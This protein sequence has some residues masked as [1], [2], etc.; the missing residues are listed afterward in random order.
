MIIGGKAYRLGDHVRVKHAPSIL[1][2]DYGIK[3][4]AKELKGI[5]GTLVMK[6]DYPRH[7]VVRLRVDEPYAQ[8]FRDG[9]TKIF[10]DDELE[11]LN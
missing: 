10:L 6:E 8:Y 9:M 5:T 1:Y 4:E 3:D 11:L 7:A 2:Y